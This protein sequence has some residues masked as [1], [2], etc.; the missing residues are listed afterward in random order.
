MCEVF[1]GSWLGRL[2]AGLSR[3]KPRFDPRPHLVRVSVKKVA[4]GQD[5]RVYGLAKRLDGPEF[6]PR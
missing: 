4:V 6:K 1:G 5:F 2:F 3:Q